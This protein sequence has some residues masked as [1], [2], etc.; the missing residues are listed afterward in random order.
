MKQMERYEEHHQNRWNRACHLV[1][2]PAILLSLIIWTVS[3]LTALGL[4]LSGWILQFVGHAFEGKAP[5]FLSHPRYLATGVQ[6]W[7][8]QVRRKR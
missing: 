6:W 7:F 5:A 1:G 4:F 2:I 3:P 8:N